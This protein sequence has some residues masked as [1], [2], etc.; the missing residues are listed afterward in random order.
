MFRMFLSRL[1][2]VRGPLAIILS[3]YSMHIR[4]VVCPL[5]EEA[6]QQYRILSIFASI[7][8]SRTWMN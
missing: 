5:L 8:T 3:F 6:V 4:M 7:H 1:F 2:M